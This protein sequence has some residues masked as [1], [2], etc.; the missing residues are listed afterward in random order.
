MSEKMDEHDCPLRNKIIED[1]LC[2][3]TVMA[4]SGLNAKSFRIKLE[5]EYPNCKDVCNNCKYNRE[6]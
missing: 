4:I 5:K 1:G 6:K 3:E 2:F